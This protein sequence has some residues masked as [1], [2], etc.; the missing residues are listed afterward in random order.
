MA[1]TVTLSGGPP[2]E[3]EHGEGDGPVDV[4][5]LAHGRVV[6]RVGLPQVQRRLERHLDD[7]SKASEKKQSQ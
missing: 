4:L 2:V 5:E 6:L 3:K 7:R 1:E